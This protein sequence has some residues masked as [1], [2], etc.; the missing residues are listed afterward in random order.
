MTDIIAERPVVPAAEWVVAPSAVELLD[1]MSE[2][3]DI[4]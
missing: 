4:V 2:K 1:G 3:M